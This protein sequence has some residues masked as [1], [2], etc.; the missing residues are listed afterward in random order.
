M[1]GERTVPLLPCG[2][3]DEVQDFAVAL[4]FTTTYRQRRPN[5]YLAVRREDLDL[6]WF[7]Q[8]GHRPEDSYGSCLVVVDDPAELFEAFAAGLRARHGRLPLTGFPR[9]TRPRPRRNA[10][11]LTGFSLVDPGGNWI[12][13]VRGGAAGP[14]PSSRLARSLADAVVAADSRGDVDQAAR[15]LAGALRRAPDADPVERVEALAFLAELSVRRG[16]PGAARTALAEL[17]AVPGAEEAAAARR[18]AAELAA[19][20]G[21]TA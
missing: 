18:Q 12:R 17:D 2:A 5:P 1:A 19:Q 13:V 10:D 16:D 4:G 14:E 3:I 15:L 11:G 21:P 9:I 20:L 8:P 7:E 6:H